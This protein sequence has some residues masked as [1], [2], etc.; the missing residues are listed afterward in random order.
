MGI[1]L[2]Q[3]TNIANMDTDFSISF[4]LKQCVDD[5]YSYYYN[6]EVSIDKNATLGL[7]REYIRQLGLS[8]NIDHFSV[9]RVD[10]VIDDNIL[11]TMDKLSNV[12]DKIHKY[13]STYKSNDQ[14]YN[15][16]DVES[17]KILLSHMYALITRIGL[18]EK[19][20]IREKILV[21]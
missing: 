3:N 14:I 2:S 6:V 17:I 16:I 13:Y 9:L 19:L 21:E 15:I 20:C 10:N 7:I 18:Y 4:K 5:L 1:C 11:N 8:E 12:T